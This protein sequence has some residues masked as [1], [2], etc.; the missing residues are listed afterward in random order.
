MNKTS[1]LNVAKKIFLDT[2]PI[3]NK[4]ITSIKLNT[5]G[6]TNISYCVVYGGIKYQMKLARPGALKNLKTKIR[7]NELM[8]WGTYIYK[9][10]RTGVTIR[11]WIDGKPLS[12]WGIRSNK[13]LNLVFK[14]LKKI[15]ELPKKYFRYFTKLNIAKYN[16]CLSNLDEQYQKKFLK[17]IKKHKNGK[18]C[19][20]KIDNVG[21]NILV[22][23][24]GK[25]Y[26]IDNEWV[27]LAPE[28]WDF[29]EN[30][31][32]ILDF[33][34]RKIKYS[35]FIKKFDMKKL[36]EFIF[37]SCVYN[38]LWTFHMDPDPTQ[39]HYRNFLKKSIAKSYS[40]LK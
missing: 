35:K 36:E 18:V 7:F 8:H 19:I 30:I 10:V 24:A 29:A 4:K 33:N 14:D 20:S 23:E 34:W 21:N 12:Q 5:G 27:Q 3:K 28:Y 1:N 39:E 25:I 32:W 9:N 26:H 16:D 2:F 11:K 15:H 38:F 17:L 37:M 13:Y 6:H 31:R 40:Y 22:D